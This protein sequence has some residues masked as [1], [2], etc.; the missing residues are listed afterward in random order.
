MDTDNT[1]T[2]FQNFK[3]KE[4]VDQ[5]RFFLKEEKRNYIIFACSRNNIVEIEIF[6]MQKS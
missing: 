4:D 3:L 6:K 5:E 1:H 2:H